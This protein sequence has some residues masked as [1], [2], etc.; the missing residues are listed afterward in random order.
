MIECGFKFTIMDVLSAIIWSYCVKALHVKWLISKV[1]E[2]N[3]EYL[4]KRQ[5]KHIFKTYYERVQSMDGT[6]QTIQSKNTKHLKNLCHM[7]SLYLNIL[8]FSA[9]HIL[10][11]NYVYSLVWTVT[12]YIKTRR[13]VMKY[14][15]ILHVPTESITGEV[16]V[17]CFLV[18]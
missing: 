1:I 4:L 10:N 2:D 6:L 16:L 18:F 11:Y 12:C 17:L 13:E 14:S 9:P 15:H 8:F 7:T 5:L 3:R